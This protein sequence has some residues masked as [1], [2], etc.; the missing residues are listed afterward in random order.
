[1]NVSSH[2][3]CVQ[4]YIN[5]MR[6]FCVSTVREN[7]HNV[8][9]WLLNRIQRSFSPGRTGMRFIFSFEQ[10]KNTTVHRH[11]HLDT[12]LG[13]LYNHRNIPVQGNSKVIA[14]E[15]CIQHVWSYRSIFQTK[16]QRRK[17][18]RTGSGRNWRN[19]VVVVFY[20]YYYNY[21]QGQILLL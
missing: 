13:Y 3:Q 19:Q 14:H 5:N 20:Y 9:R 12:S 21:F 1:M 10:T 6:Y 18:R 11:A 15:A 16:S 4:V 17:R 7:I 8:S 2:V